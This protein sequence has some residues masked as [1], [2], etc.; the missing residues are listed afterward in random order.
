VGVT[1]RPDCRVLHDQSA[2]TMAQNIFLL[3]I[4]VL[5]V[6]TCTTSADSS[7][8]GSEVTSP[9]PENCDRKAQNGD[10]LY[11]HYVGKLASGH[12]FD[13]SYTHTPA[14][15]FGFKLGAGHV[16]AGWEEGVVG[17]CVGEKRKLTI[18]PSLGYGDE[19]YGDLI[20]AKST[21][22]F[23]IELMAIKDDDGTFEESLLGGDGEHKHANPH[24]F[25]HIDENADHQISREEL[26]SFINKLNADAGEGE[27]IEEVEK[28]VDDIIREHD[29]NQDG[30]ISFEENQHF[31]DNNQYDHH[32]HEHHHAF[33]TID[34]DGDKFINFEEMKNYLLTYYEGSQE[35]AS[36]LDIDA[37]VKSIFAEHDLDQDGKIS[38]EENQHAAEKVEAEADLTGHAGD[39]FQE[40]EGAHD[41]G[42]L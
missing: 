9:P 1:V 14:D 25:D 10:I 13:S 18:P 6:I 28:T 21:L 15:P 3:H 26:I 35:D 42:E 37:D 39:Q 20:P 22:I 12:Q 16:I 31:A 8:L 5:F 34:T 7:S 19:G 38:L 24:E 30:L 27:K 11:M 23:E 33:E 32:A 2:N 36:K 29:L 40:E 17:M 41:G 4:C